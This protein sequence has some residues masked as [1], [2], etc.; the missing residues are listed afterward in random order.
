MRTIKFRGKRVD[1][2][3]WVEG[4]LYQY[5]GE[6]IIS[7]EIIEQPTYQDPSGT[8]IYKENKII[9]ETVGQFIESYDRNNKEIFEGDMVQPYNYNGNPLTHVWVVK[10][11]PKL[12]MYM[13]VYNEHS[14]PLFGM[15]KE[16]EVIGNIHDNPELLK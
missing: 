4:Y 1:N 14:M 3:E 10:Y 15:Y 8:W 16:H 6:L 11:N 12:A 7:S 2:G 9:P 13:L 5:Q